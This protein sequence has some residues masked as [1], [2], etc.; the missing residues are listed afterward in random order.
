MTAF[1]RRDGDRG[2]VWRAFLA[3]AAVLTAGGA[4]CVGLA[5]IPV[6]GSA[7]SAPPVVVADAAYVRLQGAPTAAVAGA[8]AQ[9]WQAGGGSAAQDVVLQS[10]RRVLRHEVT[11]AGEQAARLRAAALRTERARAAAKRA[12]A[13]QPAA[14]PAVPAQAGPTGTA[15]PVPQRAAV[16]AFGAPM[17]TP[18]E[19][20]AQLLAGYGWAGQFSCLDSLW[21]TESGWN[22][23]AENP[24]S[25]AYGIPQALPG[26]KM[27]S[28]GGDWQS[29]AATQIRWGLTYIQG[30]YGSPCAAWAH[31]E[32]DGWY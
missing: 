26:A 2:Y 21:D 10:P 20:A 12:S 3:K 1:R 16:P 5:A 17:A 23:Y 11:L 7:A 19:V 24:S 30:S 15:Q 18:Q 8:A 22:V 9:A 4:L 25:G 31:E 13:A 14:R 29:D 32:A 27:S 28:A 6:A